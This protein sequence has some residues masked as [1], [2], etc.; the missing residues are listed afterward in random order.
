[1]PAR[2]YHPI[3]AAVGQ[4]SSCP[5]ARLV[6]GTNAWAS[7][8]CRQGGLQKHKPR[9][10]VVGRRS[11]GHKLLPHPA[12]TLK[13]FPLLATF[14]WLFA[15][16][17][18]TRLWLFAKLPSTRLWLFTAS[19]ISRHPHFFK[20]L[21]TLFTAKTASSS[22]V[23]AASM[24]TF[25]ACFCRQSKAADTDLAW[26][27]SVDPLLPFGMSLLSAFRS[28]IILVILLAA[29]SLLLFFPRSE[30][31]S[32]SSTAAF[33]LSSSS[34]L[35]P[36][37]SL[38][39]S[40]NRPFFF[41]FSFSGRTSL[42]A[43][44]AKLA[45]SE[46][47]S[48]EPTFLAWIH[49]KASFLWEAS[50]D[51]WCLCWVSLKA[52]SW[53]KENCHSC[54]SLG[55]LLH[56]IVPLDTLEGRRHLETSYHSWSKQHGTDDVL[57]LSKALFALL[58]SIQ[59]WS[60]CFER[61]PT[62]GSPC[63]LRWHTNAHKQTKNHMGPLPLCIQAT[64]C[65]AQLDEFL[66]EQVAFLQVPLGLQEDLEQLLLGPIWTLPFAGLVPELCCLFILECI[67]G[68]WEPSAKTFSL[69]LGQGAEEFIHWFPTFLVE[70]FHLLL[71]G[72][73][74]I[75]GGEHQYSTWVFHFLWALHRLWLWF[76]PLPKAFLWLLPLFVFKIPF[77]TLLFMAFIAFPMGLASC[78]YKAVPKKWSNKILEPEKTAEKKTDIA[79]FLAD[80]FGKMYD[81]H[82][83][84]VGSAKTAAIIWHHMTSYDGPCHHMMAFAHHMMGFCHHM[85]APAIIWCH[86]MQ[87]DGTWLCAMFDL[88]IFLQQFELLSSSKTK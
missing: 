76:L 34:P 44:S 8:S 51:I 6:Q 45:A 62:P 56:R 42:K 86:M 21:E 24:L 47:S 52:M 29:C 57:M 88:C 50:I 18:F 30:R 11:H 32:A 79:I 35:A 43:S 53:S 12:P 15:K 54:L 14:P 1:M 65:L 81:F 75:I 67:P 66:L 58:L 69:A 84:H 59:I 55:S 9:P 20:A 31:T 82:L 39:L 64:N 46:P 4:S 16:L 63:C 87:Y 25:L 28:E 2:P 83:G 27:V 17:P 10:H 73:P 3:K 37:L 74:L 77:L 48:K 61:G 22:W 38:S 68:S 33:S 40:A 19:P 5:C 49:S 26:A 70:L 80:F 41:F 78:L 60:R 23:L 7:K 85:M 71:K 72:Q 36:S 13:L